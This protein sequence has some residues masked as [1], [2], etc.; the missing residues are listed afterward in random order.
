[1]AVVLVLKRIGR[2]L[3]NVKKFLKLRLGDQTQEVGLPR[4]HHRLGPDC[5]GPEGVAG[6]D[7]QRKSRVDQ[8]TQLRNP[9][10]HQ[11]QTCPTGILQ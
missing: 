3:K 6:V 1:M 10:R 7:A 8:S 9:S 4:R 5:S 2:D 11:G